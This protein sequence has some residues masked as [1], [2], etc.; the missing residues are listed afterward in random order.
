MKR[1]FIFLIASMIC[2]C[3]IGCGEVTEDPTVTTD[4]T[5][6]LIDPNAIA[7]ATTGNAT[8]AI[9]DAA[10]FDSAVDSSGNTIITLLQDISYSSTI[11]LPYSCTIDFNGHTIA[12]NPNHG[13]GIEIKDAGVENSVTTLKNGTMNQ[14][15]TGVLVNAGGIVVEDMTICSVGGTV[16]ALL[17]T[18]AA[19]KEI[20]LVKGTTLVSAGSCIAFYKNDAD[21]SATGITIED[22]TL[23]SHKSEGND[24]FFTMPGTTAG[25]ITLGHNV[26]MYSYN[27]TLSQS[28]IVYLGN[29]APASKTPQSV[30]IEDTTY[31]GLRHLSTNNEDT[32]IHLLMIGNSFSYNYTEELY[33]IAQTAGIDLTI[34][35]LY[36]AGC[37]V[38]EHWTWLTNPAE[39][40]G[41]YEFW[42]TS[43]MGRWKHPEI[44]TSYEALDWSD[45]DVITLQQHF[46]RAT[47]TSYETAISSC[48]PYAK[49]LYDKLKADYPDTTFYWQETWAYQVGHA[50]F[51]DKASQ[52]AQQNIIIRVSEEICQENNVGMVPSGDAWAI[53]RSNPQIG[54]TL[55]KS[56]LYHDGDAGGGQYLNACVWFEVLTGKSCV[57]NTWR[58]GY[59]ISEEKIVHLQLAAPEAVAARYGADYAK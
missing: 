11:Y 27:P 34:T 41:K 16:I 2:L 43:S 40:A 32:S 42:I 44:H 46:G 8:V 17:D 58:P 52:T 22:S 49:D 7:V 29:P 56:D 25:T 50:D 26:E 28:Q 33:H 47:T 5:E 20:N 37:F 39:G 23:V 14:Y 21:F 38:E 12:T 15:G 10:E 59:S 35:N 57:G 18:S 54:D 6:S 53:A 9:L 36:E 13:N 1:F 51:P 48:T 31:E 3:L 30:T 55:C 4:A 24:I 19:Y 45:W